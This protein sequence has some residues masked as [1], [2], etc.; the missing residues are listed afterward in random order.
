MRFSI[1]KWILQ[2][3]NKTYNWIARQVGCKVFTEHQITW[4]SYKT[5]TFQLMNTTL[6]Y[7][8]LKIVNLLF[9]YFHVQGK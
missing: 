7:I 3:I 2:N 6:N 5:V 8:A 1:F 9:F 4:A